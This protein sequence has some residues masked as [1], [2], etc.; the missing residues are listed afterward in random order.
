MTQWSANI[1]GM[2]KR[3]AKGN[4]EKG[5]TQKNKK[6]MVSR[7]KSRKTIGPCSSSAQASTFRRFPMSPLEQREGRSLWV[8]RGWVSGLCV[9]VCVCELCVSCVR[10]EGVGVGG[11]DERGLLDG[12]V[13]VC[14][15]WSMATWTQSFFNPTLMVIFIA[16]NRKK[17]WFSDEGNPQV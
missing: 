8:M 5:I 14:P 1:G 16:L 3:K 6:R 7:S 17:Y 13:E 11:L 10:G 12:M 4:E 9:C 2:R 15:G